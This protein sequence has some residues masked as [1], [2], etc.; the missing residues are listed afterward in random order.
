MKPSKLFMISLLLILGLIISACGARPALPETSGEAPAAEEAVE[1]ET[2]A[3]EPAE[4]AAAEEPAEE[5]A[6]EEAEM[7]EAASDSM[8]NEAPMLAEM[9]AAGDLPSVDE[10]LPSEPLVVEPYES[11]GKYGGTWHRA[12]R[13]VKDYHAWARLNYDPVLRWDPAGTSAPVLPGLAKEWEWND[14]GTELTLHFREGLKWSDG[15]PWTTDDIVFWWE[16]IELDTEITASPHIEWTVDGEPMTVE[17]IDDLT[18]KFIFPGPSGVVETMGLAFH[19]HQWPLG[20]ERFG[21]FAPKHYLEQFHPAFNDEADYALFEEK[22]FD[23]NLERPV[24][25]P[26]KPVV[27]EPGGTELILERNPYYW[28]VDPEGNQLPYIDRIHMALVEDNEAINLMAAAG[29][30]DMQHRGIQITKLPV[31]QE[32]AEA[33]DYNI[34]FWGSA[35]ASTV[36]L[37]PNQSYAD[38]QYRELMQNRD[39]R[40]ALSL[41]ID[42]NLINDIAF[43]GQATP[44]NQSVAPASGWHVPELATFMAEYDPDQAKEL[45][46]GIGLQMGADGFYDFADGSDINLVIE[47]VAGNADDALELIVEQWNEIGLNTTL[48]TVNRDLYWPRAIGNEVMINV[49]GTGSIFPLMNPDN[50]LAFNEKSFWGPQFGIWYQTGG[51]SGEE[52][53]EVMKKGQE[54]YNQIMTTTD[55]DEQNRLGQELVRDATE[56]MWVINVAGQMPGPI[57][58]KNNF[59]NVWVDKDYISSWIV[60]TP[61]NQNPSTYYFDDE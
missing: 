41:A 40:Y 17:K 7:A 6:E 36:G 39:F 29:D 34:G 3:E 30:L 56:N 2:T 50:L 8:Y 58:I 14:E 25:W 23:Y 16:N 35:S 46:D 49:W 28:K 51:A 1:E 5:A 37:Q 10:R 48:K 31:L 57:V 27:W 52:P 9:V 61:G 45:L 55:F 47:A 22:A 21:V 4:E 43:L 53:P 42:R 19:G 33:G 26:W 54:L 13:G 32:N 15:A 60:M 12:F 38:P 44:I 24:I 59:K 11:I 18:I 20:F